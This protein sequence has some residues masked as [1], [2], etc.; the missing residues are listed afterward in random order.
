MKQ[1]ALLAT[2]RGRKDLQNSG[3]FRLF[4]EIPDDP[5]AMALAKIFSKVQ[6][7]VIGNGNLLDNVVIPD[8]AF[9]KNNVTRGG[10]ASTCGHFSKVK[11]GRTE[12]DYV[13]VTDA[14]ITL[15]EIKDGD[16]FDT[17]KSRGEV[18]TLVKMQTYFQTRD[19]S[20]DVKYHIVFWNADDKST[21]SFKTQ[22]PDGVIINGREFCQQI[23]VDYDEINRGRKSAAL[24]NKA[25]VLE[26]FSKI[27][28][29]E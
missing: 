22:V 2:R 6:S 13:T 15:Y 8:P 28:S 21:I 18:D 16:N 19:P 24:Q 9:N 23:N 26:Q 14:A 25:W 29:L 20:K 1:M 12:I 10:D 5:M 4:A 11:I 27:I 7:G 3:Y 17:K